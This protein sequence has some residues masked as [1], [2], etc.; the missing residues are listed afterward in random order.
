MSQLAVHIVAADREVWE[1][2]ADMVSARTVEGDLGVMPGHE[3]LLAVLADGE[4]RVKSGGQDRSM[5]VDGGFLSVDSD[6]V[7]I[8]AEVVTEGQQA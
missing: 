8:V 5:H 7:Q 4:V 3:P 1:G 2:E 6:K